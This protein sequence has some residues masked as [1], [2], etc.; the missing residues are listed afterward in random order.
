MG[1]AKAWMAEEVMRRLRAD[2]NVFIL[3]NC[4]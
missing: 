3:I 4:D 1:G 2:V